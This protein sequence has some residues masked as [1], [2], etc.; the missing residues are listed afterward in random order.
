MIVRL[1]EPVLAPLRGL[2]P[3]RGM[4][5]SPLLAYLLIRLLMNLIA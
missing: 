2:I 1:T 4:D 5:F 3:L